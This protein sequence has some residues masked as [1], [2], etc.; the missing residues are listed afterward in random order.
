M[1]WAIL[2][3]FTGYIPQYILPSPS[4]V[5]QSF[6]E[7]IY[8]GILLE[9]TLY[10]LTQVFLGLIISAVVAIP[11]AILMGWSTKVEGLMSLIVGI[12]R[13]IPPIAWIPFAILWFGI[14]LTS[15]IFIIFI[16][17]VFPIL[18]NTIDG[19]KRIDPVLTEA[20]YTLG[21]TEFQTIRKVVLPA[22]LP[23]IITGLKVGVGIGL[24]C[25]VAAEMIGSNKGLG[26]I[27]LTSTS[28]LNTEAAI[29]G[30]LTIGIISIGLNY[31]FSRMEN[32]PR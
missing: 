32:V 3:T 11:L 15:S 23:Y 24:M 29:V 18:I 30:M 9:A 4:E 5:F 7:L 21:A 22:A 2:T 1:V 26:Y 10:T 6:L 25:T 13:P 14:G 27:I 16:G 12:L 20:A 8:N 17:S 31:L 19:V 28:M